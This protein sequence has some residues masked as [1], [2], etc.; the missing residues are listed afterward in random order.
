V[1]RAAVE[2]ACGQILIAVGEDPNQP[3]RVGTPARVARMC[4]ELFPKG[5][6]DFAPTVFENPA[7]DGLVVVRDIPLYSLCEHHMLPFFGV[8]HVGYVPSDKVIGLSKIVRLV[9]A[10]AAGLQIQERVAVQV[11]DEMERLLSPIGVGVVLEARHMCM[12]MRG[13]R[14]PGVSTVVSVVRGC[15]REKPEARAEFFAMCGIG[16]R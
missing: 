2:H 12:E 8:A 15:M 10:K 7:G 14:A 4:E 9:R 3:G 5:D 1:D 16:S 11:A 13:V 6:P